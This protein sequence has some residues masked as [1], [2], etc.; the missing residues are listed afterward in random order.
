MKLDVME[1]T[2]PNRQM[3][4]QAKQIPLHSCCQAPSQSSAFT[5]RTVILIPVQTVVCSQKKLCYYGTTVLTV[6]QYSSTCSL[7]T[8][9]SDLVAF[10]ERVTMKI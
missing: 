7:I 10:G 5:A 4:L 6:L 3:L 2:C 1:N 9:V 8:N